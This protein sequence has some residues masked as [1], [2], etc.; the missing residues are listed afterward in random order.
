M[1]QN[2]NSEQILEHT[3]EPFIY[4]EAKILILGSFPSPVSRET[5]FYYGHPR[6]RFWMV[7]SRV[8]KEETFT[9]IEQKK[10]FLKRHN[11]ALW[12]VVARCKITGASDSSIKDVVPNDI[13]AAVAETDIKRIYTTGKTAHD[14]LLKYA[15]ID[16]VCLPSPS[17]AN[18]SVGMEELCDKYTNV[19]L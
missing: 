9:N 10:D 19:L 6:N 2:K 14:L 1:K 8:Y 11:I 4:K 18:C 16:S 13:S 3:L 7:M 5:G 12:D 15:G 17:P